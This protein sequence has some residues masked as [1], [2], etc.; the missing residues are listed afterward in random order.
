MKSKKSYTCK[1]TRQESAEETAL[2]F[3]FGDKWRKAPGICRAAMH[4]EDTVRCCDYCGRP[5]NRS[6]AND[7]GTLCEDCYRKEYGD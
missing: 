3:R 4:N 1:K 6:E 7:Y 2:N 5:M